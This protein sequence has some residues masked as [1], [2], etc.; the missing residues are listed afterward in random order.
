MASTSRQFEDDYIRRCSMNRPHI[1][2]VGAG[3]SRAAL[4]NGDRRGNK[5]PLMKDLTDVVGLD[6]LLD[7]HTIAFDRDDFEALFSSLCNDTAHATLVSEIERRVFEYFASL[8]LPD[9]PTIYDHLVLSLR[10]KDIIATFNWDP[11][12]TQAIARNQRAGPMPYSFFLHGNVAIGYC[13]QHAPMF[14]GC[15]GGSCRRCGFALAS[16]PLLY[17]VT[18]KDYQTDPYVKKVWQLLD[19]EMKAGY[20]LTIFGYG[21]PSTDVEAMQLLH[22]AWN[23]ESSKQY[24]TIE[25]V[26]IRGEDQLMPTWRPFSQSHYYSVHTSFYETVIARYPRRT[27]ESIFSMEMDGDVAEPKSIPTGI[28]LNELQNWYS[29]L[30]EAESA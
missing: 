15:R 4:P 29:P 1:V 9:E 22:N 27:C 25:I 10:E 12:L 21:A 3:A 23:A 16:P 13:S 11:F 7:S 8:E 19:S 20:L 26:D 14:V 5:L 17:P 30:I 28:T 18:Q 2:L 6:S 24:K